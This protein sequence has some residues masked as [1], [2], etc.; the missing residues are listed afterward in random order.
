MTLSEMREKL[1][2]LA[3]WLEKDTEPLRQQYQHAEWLHEQANF[4]RQV[5]ETM[6]EDESK[7]PEESP[8]TSG[9]PYSDIE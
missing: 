1:L 5:A 6:K 3:K 4:L 2:E 9:A 8:Y 7:E